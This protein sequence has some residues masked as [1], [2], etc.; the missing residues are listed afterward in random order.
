[1]EALIQADHRAAGPS[2]SA[3]AIAEDSSDVRRGVLH[4]SPSPEGPMTSQAPAGP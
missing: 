3:F 4:A 1:M 2:V